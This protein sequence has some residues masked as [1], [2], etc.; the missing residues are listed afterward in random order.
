VALKKTDRPTDWRAIDRWAD[1]V[2]WIAH[3]DETMQ[4]ASHALAVEDEVWVVD[5]V[6]VPGLDDLLDQYGTV[7]GVVI[8]LDRHTRDAAAVANRHDVAVHLPEMMAGRESEID[9]PVKLTT[10]TLG[11]TG[12]GVYDLVDNRFWHEAFLYSEDTGQLIVPEAVGTARHYLAA[13]ERLGVHPALRVLPPRRLGRLT[14]ERIDVG[15]GEGVSENPAGA[16]DDA[17]SGSRRRAPRL[18]ARAIKQFVLS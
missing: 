13:G 12:Y 18:Y 10:A 15:H 17:L 11:E 16:I 5:P 2:G 8:L 1:G 3:P 9:A 14:L 4:R 6:D 7:A